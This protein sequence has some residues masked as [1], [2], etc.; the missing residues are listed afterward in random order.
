MELRI[1][2]LRDAVAADPVGRAASVAG[3]LADIERRADAMCFAE[4]LHRKGVLPSAYAI[5]DTKVNNMLF[6][7]STGEVLCVIDLDTVMPSYIFS[8]VGDSCAQ[9]QIRWL[10]MTPHWEK[11]EFRMDIFKAFMAGYLDSAGV[12]LDK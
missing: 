4:R 5:C 12:V 2:Q 11:V 3:I 9:L 8:D 10:R 1:R 7:S 6:D